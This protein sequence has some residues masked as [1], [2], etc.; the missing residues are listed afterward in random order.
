MKKPAEAVPVFVNAVAEMQGLDGPFTFPEKLLQK[1]W[2]HGDFA[3]ERAFTG[4]GR[5]VEVLHPGRWNLLGGPDFKSA[6]LRI[7]GEEITGD[8]EVHLRAEDWDAH[9]HAADEAYCGV[10]LHVVLF[11][12]AEKFSRGCGGRR[13]S[14]LALLPLLHHGLEEY[15]A[16]EAIEL[17]TGRPGAVALDELGPL[18]PDALE[19]LLRRHAEARWRQKVHFAGLR[20]DRLGWEAACHHAALEILGYRFNRAPMLRIAAAWPLSRWAEDDTAEKTL[21]A[22]SGRW[23]VQG[24]RPA[25]H[26]RRRLRQ[27]G[28]WVQAVRDWPARLEA[29]VRTLPTP[30]PEAAIAFTALFRRA[31]A[32]AQLRRRITTEVCGDAVG[33]TRLDNLIC[34]GFWPLL[35]ARGGSGGLFPWWFHWPAGDLPPAVVKTLRRLEIFSGQNRPAGHGFAQGLIGWLLAREMTDAVKAAGLDKVWPRRLC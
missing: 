16:E 5:A 14:T 19:A 9:A 8:V 34:D 33:G 35:A 7:G 2:L 1:I 6:R 15:A 12:P 3:A 26:P 20:L 24:V 13:I 21:A 32:L 18:S 10:A 11:P 17:L 28:Q 29:L 27:Y 4:D 22:E 30:D 23:S 25:N 31:H